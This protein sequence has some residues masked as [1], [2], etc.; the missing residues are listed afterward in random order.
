[1]PARSACAILHVLHVHSS[2]PAASPDS[3]NS[4]QRAGFVDAWHLL[5]RDV[6]SVSATLPYGIPRMGSRIRTLPSSLGDPVAR[7]ADLISRRFQ[8]CHLKPP[9]ALRATRRDGEP[10]ETWPHR[11][12]GHVLQPHGMEPP[13]QLPIRG[14]SAHPRLPEYGKAYAQ[15]VPTLCPSVRVGEHPQ[16]FGRITWQEVIT[17]LTAKPVIVRQLARS[18]SRSTSYTAPA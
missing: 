13:N 7:L 10:G 9:R 5:A 1:M 3:K 18:S 15:R 8:S 6:G 12:W 17:M 16:C 11:R 4:G 2:F 14:N